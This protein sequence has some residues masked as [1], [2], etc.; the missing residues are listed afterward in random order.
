MKRTS[1]PTQ[2]MD[3]GTTVGIP[4]T[5][6]L[7]PQFPQLKLLFCTILLHLYLYYPLLSTFQMT[8]LYYTKLTAG[9]IS[10]QKAL[11]YR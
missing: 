1:L 9:Y 5:F 10:T 3:S 8:L 7:H 4:E 6:S 2:S 11:V